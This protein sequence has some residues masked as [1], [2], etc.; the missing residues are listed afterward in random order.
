M[1]NALTASQTTAPEP[2]NTFLLVQ[3]IVDE[4]NYNRLSR[5]V[6]S[7]HT[8]CVGGTDKVRL[9]FSDEPAA[10]ISR[11]VFNGVDHH[12]KAMLLLLSH[13][14]FSPGSILTAGN[15]TASQ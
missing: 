5:N 4:E 14:G 15:T 12:S 13:G 3:E 2:Q 9:I 7:L 1:L 8:L 10:T 11:K 6:E